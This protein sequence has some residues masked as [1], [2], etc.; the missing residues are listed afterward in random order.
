MAGKT[1]TYLGAVY[2]R[3]AGRRGK[4]RAADTVYQDPG[5]NYFDERDRHAVVRREI[6]RLETLGYRVSIE[7]ATP[8]VS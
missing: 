3:L 8:Q 5:A 6:H 4:K 1:P 7:S 2:H